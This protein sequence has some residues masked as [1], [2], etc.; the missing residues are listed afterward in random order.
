ME[1][2]IPFLYKAIRRNKSCRNYKSLP[3]GAAFYGDSGDQFDR[4]GFL[5]TPRQS[6]E[7]VIH[8]FL[9]PQP[10]K[11]GGLAGNE[12]HAAVYVLRGGRKSRSAKGF[13]RSKSLACITGGRP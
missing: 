2:L 5:T 9:T 7:P 8:G 3:S 6:E 1:G 12:N 4:H 10:E 13:R 11:I